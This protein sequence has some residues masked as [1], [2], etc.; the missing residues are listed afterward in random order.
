MAYVSPQTPLQHKNGDYIYPLTTIDQVIMPDGGRLNT[1]VLKPKAGF[2]Y[3]LASD[4][5]PEGFEELHNT[6]RQV[7]DDE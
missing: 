6:F 4:V 2:I 1:K 3:P 5:V 7:I